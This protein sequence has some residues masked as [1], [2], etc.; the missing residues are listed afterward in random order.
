MAFKHFLCRLLSR[1]SCI[2]AGSR[3]ALTARVCR[4][5]SDSDT[6]YT[7]SRQYIGIP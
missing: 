4:V 5:L 2:D 6:V 1:Q 7:H 3:T